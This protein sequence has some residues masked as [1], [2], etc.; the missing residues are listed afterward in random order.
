MKFS[1]KAEYGLR[2]LIELAIVNG[3]GLIGAKEIAVRQG[4]PVRFLEQQVTALKKA[5]LVLSQR[6]AGG[7]CALAKDPDRISVLEVI[8]TLDGPVINMDCLSSGDQS[9]SQ[10]SCCVIQELWYKSQVELKEFLKNITIADLAQRHKDIQR[11][12]SLM[13]YI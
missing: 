7:G 11:S 1:L 5:G 6:G 12:K 4:I 3:R 13:Y 8:E 2:A 9:C 10:D